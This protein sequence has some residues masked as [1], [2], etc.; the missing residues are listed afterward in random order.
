M[1]NKN[2]CSRIGNINKTVMKLTLSHLTAVC[3]ILIENMTNMG[4]IIMH[5]YKM[6]FI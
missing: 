6:H 3:N 4:V 1:I 5:D 2:N